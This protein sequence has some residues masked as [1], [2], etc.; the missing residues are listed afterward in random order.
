MCF[1]YIRHTHTHTHTLEQACAC[2]TSSMLNITLSAFMSSSTYL[3]CAPQRR[4]E[5]GCAAAAGNVRVFCVHARSSLPI[6]VVASYVCLTRNT[7]TDT[8]T[9]ARR[10]CENDVIMASKL[11]VSESG[12]RGSRCCDMNSPT[13]RCSSTL[14]SPQR[15]QRRRRQ[16]MQIMM[17][18]FVSA[19]PAPHLD[20]LFWRE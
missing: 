15:R 4:R 20:E 2:I 18:I 7:H 6:P 13:R 10:A 17:R 14:I 12:A 11:P 9:R 16:T 3:A 5:R 8:H 1:E 19:R